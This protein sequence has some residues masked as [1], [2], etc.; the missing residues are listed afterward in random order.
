MSFT[1]L[2]DCAKN[3]VRQHVPSTLPMENQ[4]ARAN[5]MACPLLEHDQDNFMVR[6]HGLHL[7]PKPDR[8]LSFSP[9][10]GIDGTPQVKEKSVLVNLAHV[11]LLFIGLLFT[12]C[13]K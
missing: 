8:S 2:V 7:I 1:N 13:C 4:W 6:C 10:D 5:I 11:L 9:E 12:V 3:I